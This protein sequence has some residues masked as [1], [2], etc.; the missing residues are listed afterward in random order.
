LPARFSIVFFVILLPL[1][2]WAQETPVPQTKAAA[3]PNL[4]PHPADKILQQE[5]Y[6][7]PPDEIVSAVLAPRHLN[8]S[9]ANISPDKK[10][11]LNEIGDG[12]VVMSVFSK[13]FHELGGVFVDFKANRSR[14]L[15]IRN[16]V[17]IQ[18]ISATDGSKRQIVK[19]N[20]Q[21]LGRFQETAEEPKA[22]SV[23]TYGELL[24]GAIKSQ[25]RQENL[26][27]VRR[28]QG[29]FPIVEVTNA[30]MET[31]AVIKAGVESRGKPLDDFDLVIAATAISLGYRLVTNNERHFARIEEL[32]LENWTRQH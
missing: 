4:P 1:A 8:V 6:V 12:P 16:Y 5:G 10:W 32:R 24:Y 2:L 28:L 13:P 3:Q 21:V 27:K 25:R 30:I 23:I 11:F 17:G 20:P 15:T 7:S 31:Y 29:I 14:T 18:V 22:L 9:L 19:G 26:A